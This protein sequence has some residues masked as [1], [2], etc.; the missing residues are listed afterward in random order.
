MNDETEKEI[1]T[2]L[3]ALLPPIT[4][5]A[6]P[7]RCA[8]CGT[9]NPGQ[10]RFCGKCGSQLWDPCLQCGESNPSHEDFCGNCGVHLPAALQDKTAEFESNL[11]TAVTLLAQHRFSEALDLLK[12]VVAAVHS[13]LAATVDRAKSL[14]LQCSHEQAEWSAEIRRIEMEGPELVAAGQISLVVAEIRDVPEVLRTIKLREILG[15]LERRQTEIADLERVIGPSIDGPLTVELMDKAARLLELQPNHAAASRMS[16]ALKR[17]AIRNAKAQAQRGN[18]EDAWKIVSQ[19]PEAFRDDDFRKLRGQIGDL[20]YMAFDLEH[21]PLADKTLFEFDRR[22]CGYLPESA[23]LKA[24]CNPLASREKQCQASPFANRRWA[25]SP[26]PPHLGAP[27]DFMYDFRTIGTDSCDDA[28]LAEN[29]GRF[30]VAC[31]LALQALGLV[32]VA[33]NLLPDDSWLQKVGR[34]LTGRRPRAAWGVEI[35]SSGIKAV[36]LAFD[37]SRG[38]R[39]TSGGRGVSIVEC[40]I[41]EHR[42]RLMQSANDKER[43]SLLQE[44]LQSFVEQKPVKGEPVVLGLPDWMVLLKTVELPPMPSEKQEAAIAHEARHLFPVRM[45]DV[46]W[47]HHAF[48]AADEEKAKKGPFTVAYL[49]VR[50]ALLREL[51]ALCQKSGM[52]IGAVQCDMIALYNFAQF[53]RSASDEDRPTVLI[54][55][56]A[57]R[58]NVLASS[59]RHLWHRSVMFG[60][61]QINKTLVREFKLTYGQAE[62]WKRNPTLAPSIGKYYETLQPIY[63]IYVEEVLNSLAAYRKLYPAEEISRLLGC[64]GGMAAH[65]LPRYF[66]WRR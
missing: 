6:K 51:L 18:Y 15:D 60:A 41:I 14:L 33:I 17:A 44:T 12:P 9:K 47:Q 66:L 23:S 59:P 30:A 21:A 57:N 11:Q 64:G 40:R 31:G 63:E 3:P 25:V 10:R 52:K 22:L 4:A 48:A 20:A 37:E 56:G 7:V 61:D 38:N 35:S 5:S 55:L 34:L 62:E 1:V 54:D 32:P 24:V 45:Q 42:R 26:S 36:K 28:A 2:K 8:D 53:Q 43:D 65:D 58:L 19:V 39:S 46:S 49:G 13:R 27:M 29:P 50:T 16:L